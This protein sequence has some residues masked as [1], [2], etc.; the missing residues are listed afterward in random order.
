MSDAIWAIYAG[1]AAL[2]A[3]FFG[4]PFFVLLNKLVDRIFSGSQDIQSRLDVCQK[5]MDKLEIEYHHA[6]VER[7]R[8]ANLVDD[9]V[10]RSQ[11]LMEDN[12]KL[13][14][15]VRGIGERLAKYE[16]VRDGDC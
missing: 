16:N 3:V 13:R 12:R 8:L 2:L 4:R 15:Q 14:L 9:Y 10:A 11:G 7:E 1:V 5:R 6:I